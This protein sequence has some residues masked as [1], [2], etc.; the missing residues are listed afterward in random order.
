MRLADTLTVPRMRNARWVDNY[1]TIVVDNVR[2]GGE[3]NRPNNIIENHS[4]KGKIFVENSWLY[5]KAKSIIYCTKIP[6]IVALRNNCGVQ[7]D[8]QTMVTVKGGDLD[9][10]VGHFF[11]SCN[12]PPT[13]IKSK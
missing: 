12:I 9:A 3:G 13:T 6:A 10:L 2:F 11:E 8:L 7:A 1:G 5:C 4:S